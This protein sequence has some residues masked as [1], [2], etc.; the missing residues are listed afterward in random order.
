MPAF[1]RVMSAD[2]FLGLFVSIVPG[3]AHFV[4]GRFREVRWLVVGWFL[5]L[6]GG[7]Y[8]YGNGLGWTLVGLMVGLHGWIA[9]KHRLLKE[10]DGMNKKIGVLALLLVVLGFFYWGVRRV[11]FGDFVFGYA[12]SAIAY[13]KVQQGDCLLG[14]RS[15]ARE[16]KL[17]RG[18]LVFARFRELRVIRGGENRGFQNYTTVGQIV[19][20]PGDNIE[21]KERKFVVNGQILDEE[22][23]PVPGWMSGTNLSA[24][25]GP[26]SY[27][28]STVFRARGVPPTGDLVS[29]ACTLSRDDI[30]ALAIMRWFP[31][32]RR[33]FLRAYE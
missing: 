8:F 12:N 26:G 1:L 9:F 17:P 15:R 27:F 3:L 14:R 7:I 5:L 20:L 2:A 6:L 19:A 13:Q 4:E 30:D 29:D 10:I 33:G 31:L 25:V 11:V 21:I 16:D 32:A 23:Y 22:K 28:V 18:S 24:T